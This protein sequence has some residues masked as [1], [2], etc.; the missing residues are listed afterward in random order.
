MMLRKATHPSVALLGLAFALLLPASS[1]LAQ[2]AYEPFDYPAGSIIQ[3]QAG[4]TGWSGGWTGSSRVPGPGLTYP[5]LPTAGYALGPTPGNASV[6]SLQAPIIGKAGTS[7]VLSALF[8][9]DVRGTPGTQATLGNLRG[10]T[11]IIGDLA[12]SEPEASNWGIQT[13]A[14]A[15][16]SHVPVVANATTYL[17]AQVDFDVD[18]TKDRVRL[19]V[20]PPADAWLAEEPAVDD[21]SAEIAS[22]SGIF[23][24]TQQAQ[25]VDEIRINLS[26]SG[27]SPGPPLLVPAG[28]ARPP[29]EPLAVRGRRVRVNFE[30]LGPERQSVTVPLFDDAEV[31]A[32][33]ERRVPTRENGFVWIGRIA[34][35]PTSLVAFSVLGKVLVGDILTAGGKLYQ[36]RYLR[37]TVHALRE[38]DTARFPR[39]VEPIIPDLTASTDTAPDSCTTDP[40]SDIDVMVL[41]TDD[42]RQAAGGADPMVAEVYLAVE[43]TNQ[44]YLNS[45]VSQRIRLVHVDEVSYD[46]TGQMSTDLTR[47]RNNSDGV[48]DQAQTLRDAFGADAVVM[49]TENGGGYCGLGYMMQAATNAFE[50]YAYSVVWRKCAT[51]YFSFGHELGHNMGADHDC[52]NATSTGSFPYNRGYVETTP[53]AP[54]SPWRTIMAYPTSPPSTR[55]PYWSNPAVNYPV[56]GDPMG[57]PCPAPPYSTD[58]HKVLD[59]TAAVVANFRCGSPGRNDVWMKDTWNDT[60][61]EPDPGTAKEDMWRSPYIWVRTSQDG[62]LVHQHQHQNPEF[63]STNWIYTKLHNS[64][65]NMATGDLE[66]W[67]AKATPYMTW[68]GSW[69]KVA[70]VQ[71]VI[72]APHATKVVEAKWNNLPGAGHY[73]MIARWVSAADPMTHKETIDHN[74][75]TRNNNNIIWRNLNIVDLKPD[76]PAEVSLEIHNPLPRRATYSL[77]L[78]AP[79]SRESVRSF[80]GRGRVDVE[81]SSD[82]YRSWVQGGRKGTGFRARR[83]RTF[84]L[85]G[86]EGLRFDNLTLKPGQ[87]STVTLILKRPQRLAEGTYYLDVVQLDSKSGK[88][89]GGVGYEIRVPPL[90]TAAPVEIPPNPP[91]PSPTG[92]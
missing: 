38:I 24:Q 34:G 70:T 25:V 3:D 37:G 51:G 32:L 52:P 65:D 28:A 36:I 46:E 73:C 64:G 77:L 18:G 79:R 7:L 63:G 49:I 41:Y 21:S 60:G 23:W 58:N 80:L 72:L 78:R 15:F 83:C 22:F 75:N 42:T 30:L 87:V 13:S 55:V 50:G 5:G 81:M 69:S 31:V 1:V 86:D 19:W 14:G 91:A 40:P 6:R 20:D 8:R 61:A 85:T 26:T 11:L 68:P 62:A 39:E 59:Q 53:T 47:L 44:S 71:G 10:G 88:E 33:P 54:A 57:G 45:N 82:L 84:R 27:P 89:L 92:H 48:L 56:G 4:G 12:Q 74:A 17:V 9:S 66:L 2:T 35:Q 43:E 16:Y 29:A 90:T 67:V 76:Q